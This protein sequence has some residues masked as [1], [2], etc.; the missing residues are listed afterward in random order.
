[1]KQICIHLP[2][3]DLWFNVEE[4]E[5]VYRPGC[6]DFYGILAPPASESTCQYRFLFTLFI[7]I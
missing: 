2:L 5:L 3:E 4:A 1:L 6:L 7:C